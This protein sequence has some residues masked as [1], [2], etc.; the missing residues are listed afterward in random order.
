MRW[1]GLR[2]YLALFSDTFPQKVEL[3]AVKDCKGWS[4]AHL[5]LRNLVVAARNRPA[6]ITVFALCSYPRSPTK[7]RHC[8]L[9]RNDKLLLEEMSWEARRS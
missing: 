3:V 4:G 1:D 6:T 9:D 8:N 5:S 2:S 7:I